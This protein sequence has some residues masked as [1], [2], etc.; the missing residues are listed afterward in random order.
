MLKLQIF[1]L[2]VVYTIIRS[3]WF[4]NERWKVVVYMVY[5]GAGNPL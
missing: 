3:K 4:R 1:I 5:V 2:H